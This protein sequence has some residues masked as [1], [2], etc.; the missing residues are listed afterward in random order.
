MEESYEEVACEL[1]R[2]DV[3]IEQERKGVVLGREHSGKGT[4]EE[5][6]GL[7]PSACIKGSI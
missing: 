7:Q 2:Q 4:E 6:Q 1:S 3:Q 5:K